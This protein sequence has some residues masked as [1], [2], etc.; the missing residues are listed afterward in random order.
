MTEFEN[1]LTTLSK[2]TD[3]YVSPWRDKLIQKFKELF[4]STPELYNVFTKT[5]YTAEQAYNKC[6]E[7]IN[8]EHTLYNYFARSSSASAMQFTIDNSYLQNLGESGLKGAESAKSLKEMLALLPKDSIKY[9]TKG[10]QRPYKY[11]K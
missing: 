5:G 11:H 1:N 10:Y 8:R 3:E 2:L 7:V 9:K 4:I 6:L